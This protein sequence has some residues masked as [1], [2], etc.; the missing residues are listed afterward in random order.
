MAESPLLEEYRRYLT[1]E[2]GLSPNTCRSYGSDLGQFFRYLGSRKIEPLAA[3]YDDLSD[4]LWELKSDKGLEASSLFRKIE[5]LKSFYAFQVS[6]RRI[7]ESPAE[8]FRSP[9]LA[10]RLPKFLTIEEME[11]LLRSSGGAAFEP[12]R[13]RTMLELL[14]ATGMRVSELLDLKP[15]SLNL[16]DGWVRVFGK[17]AKERLIPVHARAVSLL[18][19]Y[20]VLR[21]RKFKNRTPAPELFLSRKGGRLSR[22]QFWRD[23]KALGKKAGISKPLHPHILR[24][25]FATHLLQGGA[26]LR[27]VQEMLGHSSLATTQIYTHLE[28][29][30]LKAAHRRHHPRG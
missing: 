16:E 20:L 22:V 23:L 1:L 27:A 12:A 9:R 15:D 11:R 10:E 13:A 26:D 17:G 8:P 6:E 29:S 21:E 7:S 2:R 24:H 30:G 3:S 25:T 5:A 14:Y 4:F 19:Q 18:R 28:K